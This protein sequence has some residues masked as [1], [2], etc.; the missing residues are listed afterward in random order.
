MIVGHLVR[1]LEGRLI[2]VDE[3]QKFPDVFRATIDKLNDRYIH[4]AHS[5]TYK[6]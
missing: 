5:Y 1:E 2:G 3:V 4:L 6:V